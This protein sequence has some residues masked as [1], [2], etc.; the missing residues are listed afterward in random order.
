MNVIVGRIISLP[1][2]EQQLAPNNLMAS[3]SLVYSFDNY[4]MWGAWATTKLNENW[5]IQL[6]LAAGVDIAPWETQDPGCQPT[7]SIMVQYTASGGHDS[8]YAGMNSFNNGTFGFNNL[9]ECIG[10]YSHKFNDKYWTTFEAQYMYM[11]NA[12]T[13]PTAAVPFQDAFY[14]TKNGFIWAGGLVNYTMDRI[15]PNA[16]LTLR[17]EFWNDPDGARS[18]Y[19]SSY[20]EGAFGMT[21]WPNKLLCIRPEIRFEHSFAQ[22]G[23][24]SAT[25][26]DNTTGVPTPKN[27]A[28]DNGTRHSQLTFACDATFHF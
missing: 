18:G 25:G 9:Q 6:G 3:H 23:L 26:P 20:Y 17:N 14:P 27:G 16:F 8:W 22:H 7:G 4:T 13:E 1:D 12:T 10:S 11:K 21:W 24:E 15:A 2:I 19:S 5:T 28:Y